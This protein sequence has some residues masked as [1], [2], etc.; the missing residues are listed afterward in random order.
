VRTWRSFAVLMRIT[1]DYDEALEVA[2]GI[3]ESEMHLYPK[4]PHKSFRT[5][6]FVASVFS[7]PSTY[8]RCFYLFP[9]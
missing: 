7:A 9:F 8:C 4:E 3:L 6:I 2:Q 1:G 5:H